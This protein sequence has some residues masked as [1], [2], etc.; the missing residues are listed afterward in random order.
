MAHCLLLPTA[1]CVGKMKAASHNFPPGTP[2]AQISCAP[3]GCPEEAIYAVIMTFSPS[4]FQSP[5]QLCLTRKIPIR[6]PARNWIASDR[7][8]QTLAHGNC[9]QTK[10][11][12]N[13]CRG[14]IMPK[15]SRQRRPKPTRHSTLTLPESH[16]GIASSLSP[17]IKG[18]GLKTS[19]GPPIWGNL[20]SDL[21]CTKIDFY[22]SM[23]KCRP[24][25]H[26][27]LQSSSALSSL[28]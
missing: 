18:G 1:F 13:R 27:L 16:R 22:P 15:A 21:T 3:L 9:Q 26:T 10:Q 14:R 7:C 20:V 28:T 4:E 2:E 6:I 17:F 8:R 24:K 19:S 23:E 11:K 25:H 12:T 5:T